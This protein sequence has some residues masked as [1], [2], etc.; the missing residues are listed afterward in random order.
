MFAAS[1]GYLVTRIYDVGEAE[2]RS[3]QPKRGKG[4]NSGEAQAREVAGRR[5]SREGAEI[6]AAAGRQRRG[7]PS[8]SAARRQWRG[9]SR[10]TR[11]EDE[12]REARGSL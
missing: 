12:N 10:S 1:S 6:A 3:V 2:S 8:A 5:G 9:D 7:L 4:G 11:L